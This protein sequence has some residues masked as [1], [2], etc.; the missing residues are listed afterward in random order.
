MAMF[1]RG[2]AYHNLRQPQSMD[3]LLETVASAHLG[4]K[5]TPGYTFP[6][7]TCISAVWDAILALSNAKQWLHTVPNTPSL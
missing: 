3:Q 6:G 7:Y 1:A 4:Q 2:C 5:L